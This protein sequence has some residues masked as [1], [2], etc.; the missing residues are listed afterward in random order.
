MTRGRRIIRVIR[1]LRADRHD[2][3]LDRLAREQDPERFLWEILPH[4]A[5]TFSLAIA[6]LPPRLGRSVGIAYLCCRILDT[7]EDLARDP[8]ERDRRFDDVVRLVRDGTPLPDLADAWVQDARDRAHLVLVRRSD[9]VARLLASL[10]PDT[11]ARIL[12]LVERMAAGMKRAAAIR[13]HTGGLVT[14]EERERYC[15]AVLAEPLMFAESELLSERGLDPALPP[16]RRAA[17][18][19][20]G[21]LVQLANVCRDVEKDLGRGVAYDPELAPWLLRAADAPE[22]VVAAA[23]R[24]VLERVAEL[25]RSIEPYFLGLPFRAVSGGRG[26]SLVLL[27]TTARFFQKVN[28]RLEPSPLRRVA[29]PAGSRAAAHCAA[30]VVS[31]AAARA[32]V[33]ATRPAFESEASRV[34]HSSRLESMPR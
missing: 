19:E 21:E 25:S 1:N 2:P 33:R 23:R 22:S 29:L 6:V 4:A 24:R 5:R 14:G 8:A 10:P 20:V 30:G 15:R 18:L 26:A 27:I 32:I 3:P 9:L 28:A 12:G 11:R 7:V 31:R 34:R 16:D 17:A 13:E